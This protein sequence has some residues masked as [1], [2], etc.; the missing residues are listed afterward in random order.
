MSNDADMDREPCPP[1][2]LKSNGGLRGAD[3][4]LFSDDSASSGVKN[5][6]ASEIILSKKGD[7]VKNWG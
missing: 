4:E 3:T 2:Y 5:S 6:S 7:L 1:I